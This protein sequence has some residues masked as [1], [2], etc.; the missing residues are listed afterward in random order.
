MKNEDLDKM[1]DADIEQ[2]ITAGQKLLAARK[3]Q[4][5]KDAIESARS[6]LANAGLTP[7]DLVAASKKRTAK[8]DILPAGRNYVNPD[9]RKQVWIS[10]RG[11]RPLWFKALEKKGQVPSPE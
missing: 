10:G 4:R 2:L 11:R 3:E 5:R 8:A 9:N 7:D 6:T 1:A